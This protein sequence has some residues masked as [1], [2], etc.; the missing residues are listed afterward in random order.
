MRARGMTLLP[1]LPLAGGF[2]TG[3]Y[4]RDANRCRRTRGSPTARTTPP[5][6]STSATGPWLEKLN[7]VAQRTGHLDARARVRLAAGAAR[8]RQRD[9]R[10]EHARAGRAERARRGQAPLARRHRRTRRDHAHEPSRAPSSSAVRSA[11]CSPPTCCAASAGTRPCSS[12][13]PRSCRPRRRHQHA[14]AIARGHQ[15]ARHSV[16][17]FDGHRGR[18][19]GVPRP[20]RPRL[21]PSATPCG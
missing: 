11:A 2:L 10:R 12:A 3:K 5:T 18:Q 8:H 1:Y 19:R 16:R 17:Q 15:A 7:A 4:R 9:R 21:R 20:R 13:T 6:S 14:S